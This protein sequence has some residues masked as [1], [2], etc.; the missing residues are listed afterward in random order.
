MSPSVRKLALTFHVASSIGWLGAVV[1][2]LVL[3]IAGYLSEDTAS[4]Q[5]AAIAMNLTGWFA[6]VPLALAS[7]V[8][9]FVQSLGTTWG[10]WRHYWVV[11]KLFITIPATALLLLHMQPISALADL[12][13]NA[14]LTAG[15]H[16]GVRFQ[17]VI[18]AAGALAA[19]LVATVLSIYKPK[20][21]TARGRR[22]QVERPAPVS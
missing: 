4:V 19:L 9:G 6:L 14:A 17:F 11:I 7:L 2:F 21:V 12:A 15:D 5:A 18:Q 3:S 8:S 16:P 1:G 22:R 20:G 10:L 13:S